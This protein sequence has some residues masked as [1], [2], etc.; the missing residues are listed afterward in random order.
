MAREMIRLQWHVDGKQFAEISEIYV[1]TGRAAKKMKDLFT[2]IVPLIQQAVRNHFVS[3]KGYTGA[4]QR[5]SPEYASWKNENYPG[6]LILQLR[7]NLIN[8]STQK[9]AYGNITEISNKSFEY[10]VDLTKIPYARVHDMGGRAG[11]DKRSQMPKREFM[12]LDKKEVDN[13]GHEAAR[14]VW[15]ENVSARDAVGG[16]TMPWGRLGWGEENC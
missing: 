16:G 4:W 15:D 11:R 8:A 1:S 7:R 2:R 9:G 6:R 10:G 14:F 5:L 3:Q 13:V 12:F